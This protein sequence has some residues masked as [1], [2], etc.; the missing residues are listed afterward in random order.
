VR[1]LL[2]LALLASAA[3]A[4]TFRTP[5]RD[6]FVR[7]YAVEGE[8]REAGTIR[9]VAGARIDVAGARDVGGSLVTDASGRFSLSLAVGEPPPRSDA[10]GAARA[11]AAVTAGDDERPDRP[12]HEASVRLQAR[13]G[14][15]CSE[16]KLVVLRDGLETV[17]LFVDRCADESR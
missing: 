13:V 17:I 12:A 9:P 8:V 5:G 3:C 6:G 4:G 2:A 16:K 1:R 7:H 14:T 11:I 15:L 10:E